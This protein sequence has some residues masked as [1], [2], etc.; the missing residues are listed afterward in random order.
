MPITISRGKELLRIC[1]S[2]TAK[3]EYSTNQGRSW[4]LRFSG[5]SNTGQ[6]SDLM[7]NGKG[8]LGTTSKGLF[9]STND[10]RSWIF[11]KR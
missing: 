9:Y 8:I 11:R 2:N 3:L 5:N 4:I 1:P 6:F 7:E 10:G